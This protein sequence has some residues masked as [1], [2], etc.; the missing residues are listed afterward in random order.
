VTSALQ[1]ASLAIVL[2]GVAGA[3]HTQALYKYR[4][5]DGEWV[6]TDR[7]PAESEALEVRELPMGEAG[8][9]VTVSHSF[10]EPGLVMMAESTYYAPVELILGLDEI[11]NLER[12]DRE[13]RWVLPAQS[14]SELMTLAAVG[15]TPAIAYRYTW[16]AG[17]P[18]REHLPERPYRAPFAIAA[19]YRISQAYPETVTH[20][21]AD[22]R[23]AVDFIMPIG[24]DIHA[25]RGGTVFEVTATNFRGGLDPERDAPAANLV[26]ILHEDGTYAEYAH[27]NRSTIRVKPGDVVSRGQYIADSGNTG[28]S[29]GPHLHFAVIRNLGLRVESVPVVF[30]GPQGS[31]VTP[32]TGMNLVAH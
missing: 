11:S 21:S 6:F 25:A 9:T 28:F 22:S 1:R 23:H 10:G 32:Q 13:L 14:R 18:G 12:P 2:I 4:G 31:E 29:S 3:A 27:L 5:P 8:P 24:T 20:T 7:R 17:E 26:R 30:E 19:S 15:G 16:I